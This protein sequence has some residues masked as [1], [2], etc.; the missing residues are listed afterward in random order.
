[1]TTTKHITVS[2][3]VIN[4]LMSRMLF[5]QDAISKLFVPGEVHIYY[6]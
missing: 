6:R 4:C 3:V 2:S 5:K 1:M